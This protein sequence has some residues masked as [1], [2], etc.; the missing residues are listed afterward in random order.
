MKKLL[1][2]AFA[3]GFV[4]CSGHIPPIVLDC[5]ILG[6]PQDQ[7]CI[8]NEMT[9]GYVCEPIP[10]LDCRTLGCGEGE[11]CQPN[12][13]KTVWAC[14][15]LP[16]PPPEC[17][18]P[19]HGPTCATTGGKFPCFEQA[20]AQAN[21]CAWDCDGTNVADAISCDDPRIDQPPP[22][23]VISCTDPLPPLGNLQI[24]CRPF[25]RYVDCTPIVKNDMK[26]PKVEKLY[27]CNAIGAEDTRHSCP[28]RFDCPAPKCGERVA[29]ETYAMGGQVVIDS[30]N[31]AICTPKEGNQMEFWPN[32]GNCRLCNADKTVCGG[33]F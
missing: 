21:L 12:E 17:V 26:S 23:P 19:A 29:C 7:R 32:N 1:I 16:P 22:P 14:V 24:N 25:A 15:Q 8:M 13:E 33:W 20:S 18:T 28:M 5:R 4:S 27:Y 30:R 31:G 10:P 2:A 3:I 9:Q 6:C 11:Q